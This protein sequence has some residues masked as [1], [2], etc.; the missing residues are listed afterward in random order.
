MVWLQWKFSRT[1]WV[2]PIRDGEQ[3]GGV[4]VFTLLKAVEI[5][6]QKRSYWAVT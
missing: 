4:W 2:L 3:E 6:N 1:I 5:F